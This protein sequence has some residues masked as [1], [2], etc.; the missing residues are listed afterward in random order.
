MNIKLTWSILTYLELV[1][2]NKST[3]NELLFEAKKILRDFERL[4]LV[5]FSWHKPV[6]LVVW[7]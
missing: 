5:H 6:A 3:V 7:L 4:V 2:V 1:C